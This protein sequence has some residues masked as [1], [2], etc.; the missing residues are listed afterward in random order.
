MQDHYRRNME[1]TIR[2]VR[3]GSLTGVILGAAMA[4]PEYLAQLAEAIREN[5]NIT[6]FQM[7]WNERSA[8]EYAPLLEALATCGSLRD[9]RLDGNWIGD[10]HADKVADVIRANPKLNQLSLEDTGLTASGF[11]IIAKALEGRDALRVLNINDNAIGDA[12]AATLAQCLATLPGLRKCSARDCEIHDEG[13]ASIAAM[14]REGAD[15]LV[16]CDLGNNPATDKSGQTL[17]TALQTSGRRNLCYTPLAGFNPLAQFCTANRAQ[18]EEAKRM[19]EDCAHN[20]ELPFSDLLS[21]ELAAIQRHRPALET[22]VFKDAIDHFEDFLDHSLPAVPECLPTRWQD[23]TAPDAKGLC[24]LDNPRTWTRFGDILGALAQ[25]GTPLT[26]EQLDATNHN[27]ERFL[28]MG[29]AFAPETVLPALNRHGIA[30]RK[31]ALIQPDGEATPLLKS[32][33]MLGT[34]PQLF[35]ESNWQGAPVQELRDTHHALPEAAQAQ[36]KNLYSLA[37]RLE[38]QQTHGTAR[39]R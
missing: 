7:A 4:E 33:T 22:M 12:G 6:S 1:S 10:H 5:G 38:R 28:A 11:A 17:L 25:A 20:D 36:V 27:G 32:M 14:L 23:L 3:S 9:L 34:V 39:G 35:V 13:I 24:L 30:L 8:S 26:R 37:S 29:M 16:E 15:T 19:L 31:D 2:A 21:A 18:A